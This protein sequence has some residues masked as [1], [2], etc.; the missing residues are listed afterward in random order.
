MPRRPAFDVGKLKPPTAMFRL[1]ALLFITL[2]QL[3]CA[4]GPPPPP[5]P[6]VDL[7]NADTMVRETISQDQIEYTRESTPEAPPAAAP[8][9]PPPRQVP[10][11]P[12]TNVR[13]APVTS[14]AADKPLKLKGPDHA[15]WTTLLSRH[16][17]PEGRVDYDGLRKD[18]DALDAYLSKLSAAVPSSQ[19]DPK[20][21]LA[22]WINAY[23]AF[24]VKLILDHW[25]VKSIREIDEPWDTKFITLAGDRYSLNEIENE[26]I[27]PQFEEPRIHFALV[28]AAVSCPPLAREAYVAGRLDSQ[29]EQRTRSFINN[30][31]FNV[32]QEEVVRISPIFDWYAADFGDVSAFLNRYLQPDIPPKKELYY[33]DYDWSL[34]D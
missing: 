11:P 24:T 6:P 13:P 10:P 3:S 5:A 7:A 23:N 17:S 9:P 18:M 20:E 4:D 16:V 29:L 27:R 8:P 34:N 33:L 1:L 14:D 2:L 21:A 32:T 12:P 31:T 25:P 19:W 30:E 22:Y 28:C 15:A 26:I